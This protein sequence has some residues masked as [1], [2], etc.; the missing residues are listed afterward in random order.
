MSGA[1]RTWIEIDV[2]ALRA[3]ALHAQS[4]IGPGAALM[5]VVKADAYGHGVDAVVPAIRD[6]VAMYAVAN[7]DEATEVRALAGIDPDIL[8]MSPCLPD[9]RADVARADFV[10][11][12]SCADEA[13][14]FD[15]LAAADG[16]RV[17]VHLKFD[18]GMGRIG[19][20]H[21]DALAVSGEVAKL[22]N[23]EVHSFS[24]HLPSS[25][26]D[27]EFTREELAG[28]RRLVGRVRSVFPTARVHALN[29]AGVLGFANDAYDLVRTGL[30]LYGSSPMPA[31]QASLRPV[32]TWKS[33]V[34][35]IR[36]VPAGRTVSYGRTFV[37]PRP[38]RLATVAVG[39][40]DGYPRRASNTEARV[41][42]DG[43]RCPVVGRITMDQIVVA[44]E[45]AEVDSE[46]VLIGRQNDQEILAADLAGWADT[47]AWDIF[48]GIGGRTVRRADS[49][50]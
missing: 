8:L 48:T 32:L 42:V 39:Y 25:D 40:A 26:D 15:R 28:F 13:R 49:S 2:G 44:S 20:W 1:P 31:H 11:V 29:S 34:G 30:M 27:A 43:E 50:H 24:T 36:D 41:L 38:M 3:N 22:D 21:E 16:R 46:V 7:L 45:T 5:A 17:R 37:T 12:I 19:I 47:I 9:E 4:L 10:P 33:R 6:L 35:L 23:L 18:T 14:H